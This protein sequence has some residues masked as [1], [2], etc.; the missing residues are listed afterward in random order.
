MT[1]LELILCALLKIWK[2]KK[3]LHKFKTEFQKKK[4]HPS[5]ICASFSG[6]KLSHGTSNF[7]PCCLYHHDLSCFDAKIHFVVIQTVLTQHWF[8][9]YLR[10]AKKS[11]K[12]CPWSKTVWSDV[13][14]IA[15]KICVWTK[16]CGFN[17][18]DRGRRLNANIFT[19]IA[20]QIAKCKVELTFVADSGRYDLGMRSRY[21]WIS[22]IWPVFMWWCFAL[23]ID[24]DKSQPSVRV[25]L[26]PPPIE[27]PSW[28]ICD[29]VGGCTTW[30]EGGENTL[31]W[32]NLQ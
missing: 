3:I 16:L 23:A 29:L 21:D 22:N 13:M 7:A 17:L 1:A 6:G 2:S 12:S 19:S 15:R 32:R 9:R 18:M 11:I 26:V 5:K 20:L 8:C 4:K 24:Q 10:G 30:L 28:K 25:L 14:G 31:L 27:Q